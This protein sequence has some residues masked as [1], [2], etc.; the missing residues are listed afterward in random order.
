MCEK[1]PLNRPRI[2]GTTSLKWKKNWARVSHGLDRGE[3]RSRPHQNIGSTVYSRG[4][5]DLDLGRDLTERFLQS[6]FTGVTWVATSLRALLHR[7]VFCATRLRPLLFQVVTVGLF[8]TYL[9]HFLPKL[10]LH[11]LFSSL[12][13]N[14]QL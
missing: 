2:M 13:Q 7:V 4:V 8:S 9:L 10:L 11:V 14:T 12:M 5:H 3:V 1:K 6:N